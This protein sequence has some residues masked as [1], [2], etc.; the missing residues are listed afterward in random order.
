MNISE[1]IKQRHSVRAFLDK[2]VHPQQIIQILD[3]ARQAPSGANTQPWQV[4]V[5]TG[6]SKD[7][8]S[9]TIID[10]FENDEQQQPDYNYYPTT[11]QPP[12]LDRRRACGFQ[13]YQSLNIGRQDKARRQAQWAANYQAFDAPVMLLFFMDG[14]MQTGSFMD[15]GMFLQSIMLTAIEHGLA[16]CPQAALAEYPHLVKPLLGY[17]DNSILICGMAL[18]YEDTEAA[19]NQ[20]RTAREAV[21]TF[22]RFF[23]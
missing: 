11:W 10:A 20:Y 3:T 7:N 22:T 5:L 6:A 19:I 17:P 18:G 15:F 4:A 16:T 9:A 14:I 12:Y 23:D 1:A 2:P 13:L 8:V 21:D